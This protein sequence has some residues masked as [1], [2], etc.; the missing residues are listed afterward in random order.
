MLVKHQ[1]GHM[2]TICKAILPHV[3]A[4][5][6]KTC[7]LMFT[8][9]FATA[10][11]TPN[12]TLNS[13]NTTAATFTWY[14]NYRLPAFCDP[15]A[16]KKKRKRPADFRAGSYPGRDN[17]SLCDISK[18]LARMDRDSVYG[19]TSFNR[20]LNHSLWKADRVL[21]RKTSFNSNNKINAKNNFF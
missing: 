4:P 9:P 1:I 17:N 21:W 12:N 2:P 19:K 8:S 15:S 20:A 16:L 5:E 18:F 11:D 13:T 10:L 14:G 7:H 3:T 6:T